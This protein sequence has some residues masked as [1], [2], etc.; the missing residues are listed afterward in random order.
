MRGCV[1]SDRGVVCDGVPMMLIEIVLGVLL[2]DRTVVGQ[3]AFI[4]SG[5]N[6]FGF[7]AQIVFALL[8]MI[9]LR[10]ERVWK[11]LGGT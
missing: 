4:A 11:R 6:R 1:W 10:Q 8:P 5:E 3:L 7:A 2:L 9:L